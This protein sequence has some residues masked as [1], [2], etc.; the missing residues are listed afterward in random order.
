APPLSLAIPVALQLMVFLRLLVP[1]QRVAVAE[2]NPVFQN[3]LRIYWNSS[4]LELIA[5][6]VMIPIGL[7]AAFA[8]EDN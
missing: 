2:A 1:S 5:T 7:L 8:S 4:R 6:C 3:K